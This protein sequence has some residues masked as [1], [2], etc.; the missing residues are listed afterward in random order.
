[1]RVRK[2]L[3]GVAAA[4]AVIA[5]ACTA[6]P[7]P[8]VNS[9]QAAVSST[10]PTPVRNVVTLAVD[11]LGAGFNPHLLADQSPVTTAVADLV[12]PS[13]F[14]PAATPG[15]WTR[16]DSLAV[17]AQVSSA[18]AFTVT[19]VLRKEAQ[20]SD[21]APVAAE[22]FRYLWQQMISQ[23][24]VVNAAG[25]RLIDDVAS[26]N[27]GK[28]VTV[29]FRSPYPAWQQLFTALLPSHLLK[30]SPGGFT[31]ALDNN[32]T[33]SASRFAVTS[34]DRNRG[35]I[36]LQ[37]NDRFWGTPATLDEIL[38]RRD[39]TAGQ[40]G[41]SLRSDDVQLAMVR[42]DVATRTQIRAVPGLRTTE[43]A[44][45]SVMQV[46]VDTTDPR[47]GDAPVR[48][49]L[50]GLLDP[51]ALTTIG[52]GLDAATDPAASRAQAQVLAPSQPGYTPTAPPRLTAQQARALLRDGGYVF[53]SGRYERGGI[54][55]TVVV[56]ADAADP[57]ATAVAQAAADQ[58]TVAGVGA[59]AALLPA[60]ALYGTAL[61]SGAV[62][63]VVG[64]TAAGG[65]LA[66]TLASRFGCPAVGTN[67]PV[68]PTSPSTPPPTT[69]VPAPT[70]DP[71]TAALRSGNVSG[72]C[73]PA[74]EVEIQAALS[75]A[76]DGAGVVASLEPQLWALGAVLPLYQDSVLFAARTNVLGLDPPGPL[77]SGPLAGAATWTR[78]AG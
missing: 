34:V 8:A 32:L 1:V 61:P 22:D 55:L 53:T 28:T 33:F 25:Y 9:T 65:D 56:G 12:L 20:W 18:A 60:T 59:T 54:P 37:R 51:V 6:S 47:F 71:A 66:T 75:G 48:R 73:D 7:P 11:T 4:V 26:S 62:D 19:Y 35:E 46:A 72:L 23:P 67:T 77:L 41:E 58:L 5:T 15:G 78:T 45:P 64:R 76:R 39:G 70:T 17:S 13:V 24:G 52:T 38:M 43:V 27:G 63:L 44:Q 49:G 68:A 74:L 3:I 69:T 21:G 10:A 42:A 40:L 50:L 29:T 14:R 30:D 57:V 31:D 2:S 36:L 16:D